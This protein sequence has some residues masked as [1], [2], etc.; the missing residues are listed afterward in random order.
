LTP[1]PWGIK[2]SYVLEG[3]KR[4]NLVSEVKNWGLEGLFIIHIE[5]IKEKINFSLNRTSL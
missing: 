2:K 5:K 3:F 4:A 1:N